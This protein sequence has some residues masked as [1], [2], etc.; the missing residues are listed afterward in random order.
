MGARTKG[1]GWR[2]AVL[3]VV[4]A[5]LWALK[6]L[7]ADA[8]VH[9]LVFVLGP[10]A[11]LVTLASG[12]RF[13]LESGAGYLSHARLFAIGKPCAGLNFMVAAWALLAYALSRLARDLASSAGVVAASLALSYVAAVLVNALRIVLALSLALHPVASEFWTAARVHRALGIVVYFGGLAVLH[14]AVTRALSH[15]RWAP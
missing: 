12:V 10:T 1:V 8:S 9:G 14:A 11:K 13:D 7:Y 2:V 3:V 4:G 15:R 5:G 6:R